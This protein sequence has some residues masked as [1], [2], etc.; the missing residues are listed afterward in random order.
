M[1]ISYADKVSIKVIFFLMLAL[2]A[3]PYYFYSGGTLLEFIIVRTIARFFGIFNGIGSHRWLCHN[4]FKPTIAG[5]YLMLTGLLFG[6]YGK[7]LHVVIAHRAHHAHSDQEQ[8]PH[9]PNHLTFFQMWLGRFRMSTGARVPRDFFRDKQVVFLNN[10]YWKM[11]WIFNI[12]LALID[13]K[14]ALIFCPITFTYGWALNTVVNYYGHKGES[15]APRNL[16]PILVWLT[17]GEG[18]HKNH[19]DS[20]SNYT[21]GKV[22]TIDPAKMFIDIIKV[23]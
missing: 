18:L 8:D 6:G 9:S 13:L 3:I 4:S 7:P 15:V 22:G 23:K 5:K 2:I 14:T 11:F 10:H 19:H 16:H 12:I 1:I 21:F 20:P 17:F